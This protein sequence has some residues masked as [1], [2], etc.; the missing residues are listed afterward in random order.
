[1]PQKDE[2]VYSEDLFTSHI[3]E[4]NKLGK[5]IGGE[6]RGEWGISDGI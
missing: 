2:V 3:K 4:P 1:M 5:G 6:E